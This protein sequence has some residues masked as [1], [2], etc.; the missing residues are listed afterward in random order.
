M[1]APSKLEVGLA[2]NSLRLL[3]DDVK[4]ITP[5]LKSTGAIVSKL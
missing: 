2:Q 4:I 5:N 3:Q 1:L